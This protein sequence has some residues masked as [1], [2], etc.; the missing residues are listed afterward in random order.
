MGVSL[1]GPWSRTENIQRSQSSMI[2]PPIQEN[3]FLIVKSHI[4]GRSADG[5]F[6]KRCDLGIHRDPSLWWF[7]I[8]TVLALTQNLRHWV[9]ACWEARSW[10]LRL[11]ICHLLL[12]VTRCFEPQFL[13]SR[14]RTPS[15][16]V[17]TQQFNTASSNSLSLSWLQ[18]IYIYYYLLLGT[19]ELEW[20]TKQMHFALDPRHGRRHQQLRTM[21]S[22]HL[23]QWLHQCL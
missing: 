15:R 3:Y 23:E 19:W 4:T 5:I 9:S 17:S 6:V 1:P 13:C 22:R 7:C 14:R 8:P 20:F 21:P 2:I 12:W 10:S 11:A 16:H 18:G